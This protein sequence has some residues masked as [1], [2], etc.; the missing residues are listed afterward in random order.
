MFSS[1]T[2]YELKI[3]PTNHYAI[4]IGNRNIIPG[5]SRTLSCTFW[6][7][8]L[9]LGWPTL[10]SNSLNMSINNTHLKYNK[11]ISV[12][13]IRLKSQ[14]FPLVWSRDKGL[15]NTTPNKKRRVV[16]LTSTFKSSLNPPQLKFSEHPTSNKHYPKVLAPLQ[17]N[18]RLKDNHHRQRVTRIACQLFTKTHSL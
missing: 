17:T 11:R 15:I 3:T 18:T 6:R 7:C 2:H 4:I 9:P 12:D 13:L 14:S 16:L 10:I 5:T 1:S 8:I